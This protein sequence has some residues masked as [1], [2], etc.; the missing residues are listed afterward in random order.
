MFETIIG[1]EHKTLAKIIGK[2]QWEVSFFGNRR[3]KSS[4]TLVL[5]V[6]TA[7]TQIS[8][9]DNVCDMRLALFP[10]FFFARQATFPS[11]RPTPQ[12]AAKNLEEPSD[13][14]GN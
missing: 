1:T 14:S 2:S 12:L 10:R 9:F 11:Q 5:A 13:A 7:Q 8:D 4:D 3:S 6:V